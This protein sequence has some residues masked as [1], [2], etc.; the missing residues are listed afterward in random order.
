MQQHPRR[1][2]A[3]AGVEHGPRPDSRDHALGAF[4]PPPGANERTLPRSSARAG[5][6]CGVR[7]GTPTA[8]PA[9]GAPVFR[10]LLWAIGFTLTVAAF[11]VLAIWGPGVLEVLL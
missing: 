11:L 4:P 1:G 8:A 5:Q 9:V 3:I 2:S 6:H 10:G 7:S